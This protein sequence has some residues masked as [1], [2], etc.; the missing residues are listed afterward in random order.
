MAEQWEEL[1]EFD[2]HLI[3]E[4]DD[5]TE[6]YYHE[7]SKKYD[8]TKNGWNRL[9]TE[10]H[11][12]VVELEVEELEDKYRAVA[13]V[14]RHIRVEGLPEIIHV[15]RIGG[16]EQK[17]I[18][19][20]KEDAFAFTKAMSKAVRNAYKEHMRGHPSINQENLA[21]LYLKQ[22]GTVP[23]GAAQPP[24][25]QKSSDN[26]DENHTSTKRKEMF[27]TF[28]EHKD[29]LAIMGIDE[30]VLAEGIYAKFN[31]KS[32]ADM[33][34]DQYLEATNA[35]RYVDANGVM[36]TGWIRALGKP[37]TEDDDSPF[38]YD[39]PKPEPSEVKSPVF[40]EELETKTTEE[41]VEISNRYMKIRLPELERI[42][43]DRDALVIGT[44]LKYGVNPDAGQK[45]SKE[46]LI[47]IIEALSY[48][49][50]PNWVEAIGIDTDVQEKGF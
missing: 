20:N 41:L 45:L 30:K 37:E 21:A 6:V 40:R 25:A 22:Q 18:E 2:T 28:N 14:R 11:L 4:D 29:T 19:F 44:L 35:L 43:I 33:T 50:F 49:K 27:A 10:N 46:Q 42:G 39:L 1:E 15:D 36:Y 34:A 16:H 9:A 17:K 8:Y 13:T 31:I 5:T 12:S 23:R 3:V 48:S 32:R 7:N 26:G 47:E 24:K 38:S